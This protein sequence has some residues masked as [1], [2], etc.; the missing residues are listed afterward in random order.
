M[1]SLNYGL[2]GA[3]NPYAANIVYAQSS[4]AQAQPAACYVLALQA[5]VAS[6]VQEQLALDRYKRSLLVLAVVANTRTAFNTT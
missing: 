2:F 1:C 3:G 6:Q 4:L 5:S